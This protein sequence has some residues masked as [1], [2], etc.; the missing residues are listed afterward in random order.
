MNVYGRDLLCNSAPIEHI[1]TSRI[2]V[3]LRRTTAHSGLPLVLLHGNN[4]SSFWLQPLLNELD[5][6][7]YCI[8]PDLRGYGETEPAIVDATCGAGD[9]VQDI[10]ALLDA[11]NINSCHLLGWS[12]GAAVAQQAA[13]TVPERVASVILVAPVSPFGFGGT[14]GLQGKPNADDF[15]GSGGGIVNSEYAASVANKQAGEGPHSL[16]H[17]LRYAVLGRFGERARPDEDALLASVFSQQCGERAWPGDYIKSANWPGVAPGHYGSMN[18][19]SPKY[20]NVWP[21]TELEKKPPLLRVQGDMDCVISNHSLFDPCVQGMAGQ[22]PGWSGFSP[23][24]MVSQMTRFI[25]S[26]KEQGGRV[27]DRVLADCGHS[28]VTERTREVA[29]LIRDFLAA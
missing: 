24:P 18:A 13:V 5:R 3:A 19:I 2:R 29:Q 16:R 14:H 7:F 6:D 26:Y 1:E 11:L 20:F 22:I 27:F 25:T 23:Q 9:W 4:A 8:A 15:A 10:V 28:P 21:M 17:I 12:L